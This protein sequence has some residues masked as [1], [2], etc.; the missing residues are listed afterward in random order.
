MVL[1]SVVMCRVN[2][3]PVV[4]QAPL[5]DA[6]KPDGRALISGKSIHKGAE[7]E[8]SVRVTDARLLSQST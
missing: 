6:V 1:F 4:P 5:F 3:A 7:Q 2:D 8:E